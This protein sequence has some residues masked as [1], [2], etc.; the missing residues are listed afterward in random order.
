MKKISKIVLAFM[1][2]AAVF[3]LAGCSS[4]TAEVNLADYVKY[5]YEGYDGLGTGSA[6]IDARKIVKDVEEQIGDEKASNASKLL[7]KIEI[8]LEKTENLSNG[9]KIMVYFNNVKEQE[10]LDECGLTFAVLADKSYFL[11]AANC[12][13]HIMEDIIGETSD[14]DGITDAKPE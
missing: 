1:M 14:S 5:T 13:R 3:A 8:E 11:A 4:K 7:K 6:T 9:E 12:E 2:L 10:L